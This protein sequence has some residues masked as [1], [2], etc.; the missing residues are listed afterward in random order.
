MGDNFH[1]AVIVTPFEQMRSVRVEAFD[2][3]RP[4]NASWVGCVVRL[5]G[6]RKSRRCPGNPRDGVLRAPLSGLA[7]VRS[8]DGCPL[9]RIPVRSIATWGN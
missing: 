6:K 3:V 4:S 2:R 5:V 8:C 9:R 7:E 1:D